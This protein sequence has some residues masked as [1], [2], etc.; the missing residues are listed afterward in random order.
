[1]QLHRHPYTPATLADGAE[2][3]LRSLGP[4]DLE[5]LE[6]FFYSLSPES[7]YRRFMSPVPRPSVELGTKLLA[8][9]HRDSEAVAA[10]H[11]GEIVGVARYALG[12]AGH[13]LAIVVADAWQ[14][15]GVSTVLLGRLMALARSRGIRSFNANLLADNRPVIDMI[16]HA[17][18][19]ARFE[20]AGSEL[21]AR[22]SLL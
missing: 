6:R 1:M 16:R 20:R 22:I 14:R 18:P 7:V 5:L 19:G 8:V 12:P 15:R 10:F 17:F 13:D 9:D 21:E 11:G 2:L 4:D 3:R